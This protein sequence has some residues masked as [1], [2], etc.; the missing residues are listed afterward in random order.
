METGHK[1]L[2]A[3]F[4]LS[5]SWPVEQSLPHSPSFHVLASM[6]SLE[7]R[8]RKSWI[9]CFEITRPLS[10]LYSH[11]ELWVLYRES[12]SSSPRHFLS[13]SWSCG[14][15]CLLGSVFLQLREVNPSAIWSFLWSIWRVWLVPDIWVSCRCET[16][17]HPAKGEP[18][19]AQSSLCNS[20][21]GT[22]ICNTEPSDHYNQSCIGPAGAPNPSRQYKAF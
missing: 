4:I 22:E 6:S 20:H 18:G 21:L 8:E 16:Q 15:H 9:F 13:K 19:Y 10:I 11:F 17:T 1:R 7:I 5:A 12:Q 2:V 3:V 14:R